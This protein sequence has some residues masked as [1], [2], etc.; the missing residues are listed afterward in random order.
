MVLVTLWGLRLSIHIGRQDI[1]QGE[2]YRYQ[3]WREEN[4][5][6][7]WWRSFIKVFLLQGILVWVISTPLLVDQYFAEPNKLT[8]LDL[9]GAVVWRI[10]FYFDAVGDWQ[11]AQ[12]KADTANQGKLLTS[13]VWS[14][15]HHP[16]YSGDAAQWWGFYLIALGTGSGWWSIFSPVIMCFFN[17]KRTWRIDD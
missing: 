8:W 7:W 14:Y 4:G 16:N 3:K 11:L 6:Q 5:E 12:F 17:E 1:G 9:L 10:G 13:G 2:A 15:S